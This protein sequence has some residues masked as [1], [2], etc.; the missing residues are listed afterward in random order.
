MLI[1]RGCNGVAPAQKPSIFGDLKIDRAPKRK[2]FQP[3]IFR[4]KIYAMRECRE[5]EV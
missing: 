1:F 4:A 3:T 2:L 5:R